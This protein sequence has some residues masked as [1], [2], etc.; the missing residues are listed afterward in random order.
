MKCPSCSGDIGTKIEVSTSPVVF[1]FVMG[2]GPDRTLRRIG[3]I[4]AKETFSLDEPVKGTH[5]TTCVR[6]GTQFDIT[7]LELV[8]T[9]SVCG[10]EKPKM[11]VA[12]NFCFYEGLVCLECQQKRW[13]STCN[14]CSKYSRCKLGLRATPTT[15]E[16]G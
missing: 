7:D 16:P 6:C 11:T 8:P 12:E 9:C 1:T 2:L 5:H 10:K 13:K 3:D 15:K 14:G 4:Y